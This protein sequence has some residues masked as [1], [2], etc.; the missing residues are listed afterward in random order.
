MKEQIKYIFNV[1]QDQHYGINIWASF[2]L[3]HQDNF[4]L[5]ET[6]TVK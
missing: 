6:V 2:I 3:N 1:V 4:N 5:K